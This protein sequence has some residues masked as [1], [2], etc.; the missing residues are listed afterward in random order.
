M[1]R[2]ITNCLSALFLL[3][4]VGTTRVNAQ[5][6]AYNWAASSAAYGTLV[7]TGATAAGG[8][9][10][11][12][13]NNYTS[14]GIPFAFSFNGTAYPANTTIGINANGFIRIGA[15]TANSYA[16]FSST[17]I[18]VVSAFNRDIQEQNSVPTTT[19]STT[20]GS[21]IIT[22]AS[23]TNWQVGMKING[24]TAGT[25]A[26][27]IPAGTIVTGISGT[28]ITL[29]Q[30]ATAT[31]AGVTIRPA[32]SLT[33][34]IYGTAPNR[35]FVIQWVGWKR[36][37]A[38]FPQDNYSFQI[39]LNE[40][41]GVATAQT[42]QTRF[43]NCTSTSA[44]AITVQVGL[45]GASTADWNSRMSGT[46]AASLPGAAITSTMTHSNTAFPTSGT[47]WTWSPPIPCAGTPATPTAS[48]PAGACSGAAFTI[49]ATG[50]T[51][52]FSQLTCQWQSDVGCTGIWS[53]VAGQTSPVSGSFTQTAATCY[54]LYSFCTPSASSSISNTVNV[55]MNTPT[56][57]YCGGITAP[58]TGSGSATSTADEDI[59]NVTIANNT[60]LNNT[61]VC[62]AGG[63]GTNPV[64]VAYYYS[65]YTNLTPVQLEQT[66]VATFSLTSITCGGNYGN[67]MQIFID[68]NAD[69]DFDDAG[70]LVYQ[71]ATNQVGPH[72]ETG[73]FT[74]P[75]TATVGTTR[76]RVR[77][78]EST[79]TSYP[80]GS[81]CTTY[82]WG[83]TEDYAA[84]IVA[85]TNCIGT[86]TAGGAATSTASTAC[87]LAS[88]TLG[89]ASAPTNGSTTT[90]QW[91][92]NYNGTGWV[93]IGANSGVVAG[94]PTSI[95]TSVTG[96]PNAPNSCDFRLYVNCGFSGLSAVSTS[97]VTVNGDAPTNCYC[98]PN[99]TV[100]NVN[101]GGDYMNQIVDFAGYVGPITG[102][103]PPNA[104]PWYYYT[105]GS[106]ATIDKGS[107]YNITLSNNPIYT[108]YY[109]V[110][111]DF[112]QNG[113]FGDV[114]AECIS[115][116]Q[117]PAGSWSIAG[118]ANGTATFTCPD[119][120]IIPGMPATFVTRIRFRCTY[121]TSN[122]SP[123]LTYTYGETEDYQV[124][125]NTLPD[126]AGA[127]TGGTTNS[128]NPTPCIG[129]PFNLSVSGSPQGTVSGLT[130]RWETAASC[131]GPWTAIGTGQTL[132]YTWAP[133][134]G[135]KVFRRWIK[136]N[137]SNLPYGDSAVSTCLSLTASLCYCSPSHTT[138][139][140][141]GVY[142]DSVELKNTGLLYGTGTL[143]ATG[144][145][146]AAP[147]FFDHTAGTNPGESGV[148]QQGAPYWAIVSRGSANV[149]TT[150]AVWFDW[151]QDGDFIDAS[152]A[153]GSIVIN[154]AYS[155]TYH[156]VQVPATAT[157][158]TTRM[159][160]RLSNTNVVLDP[161]LSTA[162]D[163]VQGESEDYSINVTPLSCVGATQPGSIT[164]VTPQLTV[165]NDFIDIN[166]G[167]SNGTLTAYQIDWT[168]PYNF[169]PADATIANY[170]GTFI[171]NINP[172]VPSG[173]VYVRGQYQNGGC[174][175]AYSNS[176]FVKLECAQSCTYN[177][178]DNDDI[179]SVKLGTAGFATT[180]LNNNQG[181]WP[182]THDPSTDGYQDFQTIAGS[183]FHLSRATSYAF[184]VGVSAAYGEGVR[185]WIDEDGDGTF[186][187]AESYY[188]DLPVAG[189]HAAGTITI[190]CGS[191]YVGPSRMRVMDT[192]AGTPNVDDCFGPVAGA[193][194][195]GEI[196]DYSIY[197]DPIAPL[198]TNPTAAVCIGQT[199]VLSGT[200]PGIV[201]G[202]NW[203]PT[204]GVNGV[205]MNPA[206][207][208]AAT[209]TVST[210]SPSN[211]FFTVTGTLANGCTSSNIVPVATTPLAGTVTPIGSIICSGGTKLLT[212]TGAAGDYQWQI[213]S[214]DPATNS[215]SWT[216]IAGATSGLS[217]TTAPQTTTKWY[218]LLS[219]STTC[220]DI[221]S[222]TVKVE[223]AATPV[224]TFTNVTSTSVVVNWPVVG[225]GS[226]AI[227]WTGAGSGSAAGVTPPY[228]I[229]GLT[230]NTNLSVTVT[231]TSPAA[232]SG[233]SAGTATVKTLCAKPA[234][235]VV[236]AT[237]I[238]SITMT[239][240]G[241]GPWVLYY[242]AIWSTPSYYTINVASS[243]YTLTGLAQN[244]AYSIYYTTNNCPTVGIQSEP[245]N[246]IV[247]Y[248]Q[249]NT[250]ACAIPTF[251]LTSPCA[252]QIQ[253]SSL[254]GSPGNYQVYLRRISPTVSSG[255]S[256]PV[257]G[258]TF[259]YVVAPTQ[260]GS[261][262]EVF[263]RS[264]CAASSYSQIS[265]IQ[266]IQVKAG[267]GQVQNLVLSH[268]ICHGFTATWNNEYCGAIPPATNATGYTLFIRGTGGT[269]A[270][271]GYACPTNVKNI[272]WLNIAT[273][274]DVY[275][276]ANSCNGAFGPSS[277]IETL[278]TQSVGC[279][280]D[281]GTADDQNLIHPLTVT[282]DGTFSVFPNPNSGT[283]NVDITSVN[284][285]DTEVR[286]EVMNMLGATVLT[287]IQT[288]SAG[289]LTQNVNLPD[290]AAAGNYMI[291][292][293]VGTKTVY[294]SS[295][296]V[297]K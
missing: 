181:V 1:K 108:E 209:V 60:T 18:N 143:N 233:V 194:L 182:A 66:T 130:Y 274:Y 5:V 198:T 158:G 218:R 62:G 128:S 282:D 208:N 162:P 160:V 199:A 40:A 248:T 250:T 107:S 169:A 230:S 264:V 203:S 297:S 179:A 103:N 22:V 276:R 63:A 210:T 17:N 224:V 171:A 124:T 61:S 156:F 41:G 25:T 188:N 84:Q 204:N 255:V 223:I 231:M 39:W 9:A 254:A 201:T 3:L 133:P 30:N 271:L 266:L 26:T 247:Q 58:N 91:Q 176:D 229:N 109:R 57:C 45:K 261:V 82:L 73:T 12:D 118:N 220:W 78:I 13:D 90:Y 92:E 292:V 21:N 89:T 126:C 113:V 235:P 277:N 186:S 111:V 253:V 33:L 16:T 285:E 131:A 69:G 238:N 256:Y 174:P 46:W 184:Q 19:C 65:N 51:S 38:V 101:G 272:T 115:D 6:S 94:S 227:N 28:T 114:A 239:F 116:Q 164:G 211:V 68:Y 14:T 251:T 280:E 219:K 180:I 252:N 49:T 132:N 193:R 104:A 263:V 228:T 32:G 283:F 196:E 214:L 54:R 172:G 265:A 275:V 279:R 262:W 136:C 64:S 23:A 56:D 207:G 37:A 187:T 47:I 225:G 213:S 98:T 122:Q 96:M 8:A 152:E 27:G 81:A 88:F 150:A 268:P 7:G 190:P 236:T 241:T 76:I 80:L 43:G 100:G 53:N 293:L 95:T 183:P 93:A 273:S 221:A 137:L 85:T 4:L 291:R 145:P 67:F 139:T 99:Y 185:V 260:S 97:A 20:S 147:W 110:W 77:D 74:I 44:T 175:V 125:V 212:A 141:S 59:G 2:K 106:I 144:G 142:I 155:K 258:P 195:W 217:Y 287:Q 138:G 161:C 295:V 123:C 226:Y 191:G 294:T 55:G 257:A 286:I 296:N 289:H 34:W 10:I 75:V 70:E 237:T 149:Q 36:F 129:I 72:T 222:N 86:P 71:P 166:E 153:I 157:L 168:A 278:S 87:P 167:G 127:P 197:I 154:G 267:C 206:N 290:E 232:C 170:L 11:N 246:S 35:S 112:N 24:A 134:A 42:V 48:G 192:Y 288:M 245:S 165:A 242:H 178:S 281:E 148:V 117:Y 173:L 269:G 102:A 52:G 240:S 234:V 120:T 270:W 50:Y 259:N 105:P 205:V 284:N 244:T 83:E 31:G 140:G 215:N 189:L 177:T 202:W 15:A 200:G 29:S 216:D 249:P 151:N 121:A 79:P 146:G 159:R 163:Y 119:N 243:P 135:T